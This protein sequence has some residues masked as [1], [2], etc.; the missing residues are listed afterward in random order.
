MGNFLCY[1]KEEEEEPAALAGVVQQ[2]AAVV[3]PAPPAAEAAA[4]VVAPAVVAPATVAA[5]VAPA[6][7][8]T[9]KA[10]LGAGCYWGTE[11]YISKDW[12]KRHPGALKSC[13]VGFMS[14]QVNAR[15]N[16]SYQDVCTGT[17]GFV[18]VLHVEVC[19]SDAV[20]EDLL[21]FFFSFHD[22]T[23]L[24]KQGNDKGTQYASAIFAHSPSQKAIA[25]KVCASVTAFA[26]QGK[27]SGA[28]GGQR[29]T[30]LVADAQVFYPAQNTHQDYLEKNPRGYC[31]HRI[32][33]AA[34]ALLCPATFNE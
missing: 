11:K 19:G 29:C 3:S 8:G 5:A 9:W 10:T 27:L 23:T 2:P 24:N 15:S 17:T 13:A 33:P 16:P 12:A 6:V 21:R 25:E 34:F 4:T 14:P 20:Y 30:T 22:P 1:K 7:V 31:N 28:Y 32:R 18:E 26:E